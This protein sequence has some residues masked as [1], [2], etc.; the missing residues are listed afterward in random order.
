MQIRFSVLALCI[1]S[2]TASMEVSAQQTDTLKP[3]AV[4]PALMELASATTPREYVI[5]GIAISG[6]KHLDQALLLSISGISKGD[7]VRIPGGD[8]FSKA[9]L[10]LWKQNLFSNIQIYYTKVLED[11]LWIEISVQERP[12]LSSFVFKGVNKADHEELGKKTG[13]V[14]GKVV[15][16]N[17]KLTAIQNIE[18]HYAE[19]GFKRVSVEVGEKTDP[20]LVNSEILTFVVDR[21]KKV[22]VNE[23]NFYGNENI[24]DIKLKKQMKGTKEMSKFTLFPVAKESAYGVNKPVTFKEYM[25]NWGFLSLSRT[26]EYIDPYFRFKLFSS[27]KFDEKKYNEDKDKVIDLC[28]SLGYRDAAIVADTQYYTKDGNLN[29]DI[30]VEEGNKYY[31]GNISWK[32]NT[33]YS[34]SVLN[35]ALGIKKGDIYNLKTLNKKL[36]KEMSQEGGDI[37]SVYMDDGYLFF[38]IE[39]VETA[40]YNDIIDHEIRIQEGPQATIKNVTISGNEKTNEH[41]VR[42]ELRTLPG[43]KFSRA[44]IIRSQREIVNLGFFDQEKLGINPVPNQEDGTV[45]IHYTVEEKSADQVELSGGFGGGIGFTGTLGLSFNNFSINNIWNKKAWT[46]LPSG[47]G[48]KLSLRFQSNG[49]QYRSY[50]ISFVEPWLGGKKRN[51]LTLSYANTKYA[52]R[53]NYFTNS[54]SSSADTS[55]LKTSSMTVGL[56]KQLKWPDDYFTLSAAFNYT[57]YRL[58]SYAGLL[59]GIS[60]LRSNNFNLGLNLRRYSLDQPMFPQSGSDISLRAQLTPPYSLLDR[61]IEKSPNPYKLV[62][63]HKWRFNAEWFVPIGK[64]LG[65]NKSK[66]FVLRLAAKYGFIGRYNSKLGYSPF[67]RFQVGDAGMN[68]QGIGSTITGYDII[69]HRGYYVYDNSDPKVNP[70][71]SQARQFFTI[72]NKY[73]TELRFPLSTNPAVLGL[74]FFEAANGWYD[75]KDYNPFR[76]RRSAGVGVRINMPSIGLIGFDYGFGFDRV[77]PGSGLKSGARFTFMFGQEPE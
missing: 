50:N 48:Q 49:K 41:V 28:N 75:Y 77:A 30:K 20:S 22:R 12:R 5:S 68:N 45:D 18:K 70:E 13:L 36:G 54:Y 14:K 74:A 3:L 42:R 10:N 53:Y 64:P 60:N 55:Y 44:D 23:V 43:E 39:P 37:S 19:K 9:I 63:Y 51:S 15:T 16:E 62:E 34:D 25:K 76:L 59:P 27:A 46:P 26:K 73:T 32:G 40:V 65:A 1:V 4:D 31:F 56:G 38:R 33:K 24:T 6:T 29:V 71:Q 2:L 67:E 66:Q 47:D 61:S 21:G 69:A 17:M 58:R 35:M 11:S 72:F 8:N 52:N 7:R 57:Q